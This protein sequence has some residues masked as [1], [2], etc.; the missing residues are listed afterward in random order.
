MVRV[1]SC[2]YLR[3]S[4]SEDDHPLFRRHYTR[5]NR[6]RG[7]K[8]LR[9]FPHCCPE[10]VRRGYCGSSIHVQ[11]TFAAAVSAATQ[12]S[13]AVLARFEPSKCITARVSGTDVDADER[14]LLQPGKVVALPA[15]LF[16][17]AARHVAPTTTWIRADREG[18]RKQQT[19]PEDA[20][21]YVLNNH[22]HPRWLYNYDS[23]TSRA[24][25]E[26]THHLVVYVFLLLNRSSGTG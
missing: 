3:W 24:R 7:V 13:L 15:S 12:S 9:C 11:V 20:V 16:D 5:S 4:C 10:H 23:S 26:M 17:P 6:D 18:D 19:L 14:R 25:R 1:V 21:L 2:R 8:F 22:R